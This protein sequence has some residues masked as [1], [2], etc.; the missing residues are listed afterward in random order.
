ML[1]SGVLWLAGLAC[2]ALRP[3][4]SPSV[5]EVRIAEFRFAPAELT[6][7]P[8]DTVVWT[9]DDALMHSTAADSGAWSSPEMGRG[10]RFR[11]VPTRSGRFYY[12][13]AA[14]PVM[15]GTLVVRP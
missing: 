9:N 2:I 1:G 6:V 11:F 8:G 12:H 10:E 13:C 4:P 15:R 14:H 5:R 7:S 3:A